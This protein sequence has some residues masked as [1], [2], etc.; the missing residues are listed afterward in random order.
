MVACSG[1]VS[2]A[3]I[4]SVCNVVY[5]KG[6]RFSHEIHENKWKTSY[7]LIKCCIDIA[8]WMWNRHPSRS[9]VTMDHL[10]QMEEY[11]HLKKERID[12]SFPWFSLSSRPK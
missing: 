3:E 2:L 10:V 6:L 9:V 8:E 11:L 5:D 4:K 7:C 1:F 12:W